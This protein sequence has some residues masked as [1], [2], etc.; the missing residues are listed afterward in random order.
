M[1]N[2]S[3]S[4]K[5]QYDLDSLFQWSASNISFNKAKTI[6]LRFSPNQSPFP[7][8]YFLDGQLIAHSDSCRDLGVILSQ[9]LSW[10]NH[11]SIIVSKAYKILGLI[12]RTFNSS[13]PT[14]VR[15]TLY[16]SLVRSKLTYCCSVC[17]P[18][19]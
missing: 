4:L 15:K 5:L 10:S 17:R 3:D 12:R 9:N 18:H 11:I 7:T 8:D 16:L 13:T 19:F 14:G 6:L 1:S 2:K